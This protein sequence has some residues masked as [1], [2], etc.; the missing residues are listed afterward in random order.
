M[1]TTEEIEAIKLSIK[2]WE[3]DILRRFYIPFNRVLEPKFNR[4]PRW[5]FFLDEV[6]MSGDDCPLCEK[7][8]KT[9]PRRIDRCMSCPYVK[10][11]SYRCDS[12]NGEWRTFKD[13]PTKQ[14]CKNMITA[15]KKMLN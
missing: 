9:T 6:K 5:L 12:E 4:R 13:C 7:Y 3:K 2:H 11:Y 14:N 1:W 10:Y 8:G 15:L